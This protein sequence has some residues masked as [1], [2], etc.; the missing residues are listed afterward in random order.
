[1]GSDEVEAPMIVDREGEGLVVIDQEAHARLTGELAAN[2]P[3]QVAHHAAF[4][5]AARVHDNG[6]READR[7]ATVDEDGQPHTF[8]NVPDE[9]YEDLWRRGIERAAAVDPL[10]GLLVGLHGSRFF[11]TRD[12]PGMR[13]LVADERARQARVLAELGLGGSWDDLPASVA[14]ASDWI[15]MLD[16][17]SLLLCGAG[18][19]DQISPSVGEQRYTLTRTSLGVAIDPWPYEGGPLQLGVEARR[20]APGP[21]RD[22]DALRRALE[23]APWDERDVTVTPAP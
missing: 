13:A 22:H 23:A 16:A 17:L 7:D 9:I 1:M 18:L 20:I 5:A 8:N 19:P 21:Y 2:L 10:V 3:F 12:S 11:E 4:V 15:A 6:W 14:E